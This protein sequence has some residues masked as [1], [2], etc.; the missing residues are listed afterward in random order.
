MR[1]LRNANLINFPNSSNVGIHGVKSTSDFKFDFIPHAMRTV[2]STK[3]Q[4]SCARDVLTVHTNTENHVSFAHDS[5]TAAVETLK[6]F[7]QN[8][9]TRCKKNN[10]SE[11]LAIEPRSAQQKA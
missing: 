8:N 3:C 11:C 7:E 5:Q 9:A 10:N 2:E 1:H 4:A 6:Y